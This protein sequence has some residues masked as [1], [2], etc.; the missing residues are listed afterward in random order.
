MAQAINPNVPLRQNREGCYLSE[1]K[2]MAAGDAVRGAAW[3]LEKILAGA[4]GPAEIYRWQ[5][6][7]G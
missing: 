7:R 2:N 1:Q 6:W 3:A 4:S 5:A